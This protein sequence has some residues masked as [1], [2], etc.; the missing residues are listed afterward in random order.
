MLQNISK[1][2][3]FM[4]IVVS[5]P[6][7]SL[8]GRGEKVNH[9]WPITS[10]PDPIHHPIRHCD[11]ISYLTEDLSSSLLKVFV[12]CYLLFAKYNCVSDIE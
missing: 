10:L 11:I 4:K 8:I 5:T 7:P 3:G 9:I 12:Q 2:L 6:P 1:A